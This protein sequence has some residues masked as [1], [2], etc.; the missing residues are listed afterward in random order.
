M[1]PPDVGVSVGTELSEYHYNLVGCN[2]SGLT[3]SQ[4]A[5]IIEAVWDNAPKDW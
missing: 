5:D 4:I 3:F 2:D 1:F